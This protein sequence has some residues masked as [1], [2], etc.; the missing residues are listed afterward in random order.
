MNINSKN[1]LNMII[2]VICIILCLFVVIGFAHSGRTDANGGH[3]NHST[4]EYHYHTG[5]YAGRESS[6]M[7][8]Y[9]WYG[10]IT[11]LA[12]SIGGICLVWIWIS[13]A[14]PDRVIC[15]LES[16]IYDYRNAEQRMNFCNNELKEIK[17][18]A[19]VPEGY[20]IGKDGLPKEINSITENQEYDLNNGLSLDFESRDI[21]WGKSLTVYTVLDGWKLHLNRDCCNSSLTFRKNVYSFCNKRYSICKKCAANYQMPNMEWYTEYLKLSP[22]ERICEAAKKEYDNALYR[23]KNCYSNCNTKRT[24]FF[25]FFSSSK[26]RRLFDLKKEYKQLV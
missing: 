5:E 3:Y 15:C 10:I 19:I 17:K 21:N 25:L 2:I 18:K 20:E 12:L 6:S 13:D 4:G 23:L 7:P 14:L 11:I 22:Q 16:A 1:K 8:W 26:K 9:V 24:K